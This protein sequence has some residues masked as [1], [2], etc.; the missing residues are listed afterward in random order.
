M[1]YTLGLLDIDRHITAELDFYA[2]TST[3]SIRYPILLT[4]AHAAAATQAIA[5]SCLLRSIVGTS[6]ESLDS[7]YLMLKI[8]D[9]GSLVLLVIC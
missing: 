2:D 8:S 4:C 6:L 1:V 7:S 9:E 5:A 3:K